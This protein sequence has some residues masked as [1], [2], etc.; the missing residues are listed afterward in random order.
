MN[1]EKHLK[2]INW[3]FFFKWAFWKV[4]ATKLKKKKKSTK[5]G[6]LSK[7]TSSIYVKD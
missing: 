6:S 2:S 4:E 5:M 1:I 3:I 7:E